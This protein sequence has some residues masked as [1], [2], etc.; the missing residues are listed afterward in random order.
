MDFRI[1]YFYKTNEIENKY[2]GFLIILGKKR[3]YRLFK[4]DKNNKGTD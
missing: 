1:D 3:L 2:W 4:K